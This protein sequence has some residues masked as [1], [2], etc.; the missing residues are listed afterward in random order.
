VILFDEIEKA[1]PEV[2]NLLLQVLD[3]GRL[4]DSQGRI[5]NFKNTLIV[6]TSNIGSEFFNDPM[7]SKKGVEEKIKAETKKYFRP[8]FLNRIDE[9][10]IFNKLELKE[11][12]G[13]VEI[14]FK[15]LKER[16]KDKK[17]DVELTPKAKE[18]IAEHGFS[19]EYGAR[20]LKRTIQKLV[21][22]PL[23]MQLIKGIFKE[24][25]IVIVDLKNKELVLRKAGAK[26]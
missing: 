16:L 20:P 15:F 22:D 6:M 2:F 9:T 1:H 25:D 8:E 4:T 10:I 7:S 14:Q 5:V 19:P 18:F 11:I 3:D 26:E 17:I 24:G 13:I 23:S 21:I 12:S